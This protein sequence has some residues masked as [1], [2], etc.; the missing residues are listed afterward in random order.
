MPIDL[1]P[2]IDV[3]IAKFE[4]LPASGTKNSI[5]KRMLHYIPQVNEE[6]ADLNHLIE[7]Y[8]NCAPE[9]P[10]ALDTLY[11]IYNKQKAIV[12][13]YPEDCVNFCVNFYQV[14]HVDLF[15]QIKQNFERL[16]V[17]SISDSFLKNHLRKHSPSALYPLV[18][19]FANMEPAKINLIYKAL[20]ALKIDGAIPTSIIDEL[21]DFPW[22]EY[23]INF[24]GGNNSVNFLLQSIHGEQFVLSI[25]E[26]FNNTMQASLFLSEGNLDASLLEDGVL[27]GK[28]FKVYARR[29]ALLIGNAGEEFI[30]TLEIREYCSEG[31]LLSLKQRNLTNSVRLATAID[32]YKQM[33]LILNEIE[34]KGCAFPDMK[35]S[36][37]LMTRDSRLV[38]GDDKSLIFSNNGMISSDEI[39]S[40]IRTDYL[41]PPEVRNWRGGITFRDNPTNVEKLHAYQ[42]GKNLYQYLTGCENSYLRKHHIAEEFSFK[43]DIFVNPVGANLSGLIS[44]LTMLNHNRR[45]GVKEV[46]RRLQTFNCQLM[47]LELENFKFSTY[48]TVLNDFLANQ[49]MQVEAAFNDHRDALSSIETYLESLVSIFKNNTSLQLILNN[50]KQVRFGMF[51][52]TINIHLINELSDQFSQIPFEERL[53]IAQ[54]DFEGLSHETI[55]LLHRIENLSTASSAGST[56]EDVSEGDNKLSS[57][58]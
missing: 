1:L 46:Y 14:F 51:G 57:G 21:P 4:S 9:D 42:L 8:N 20:L 43:Y 45:P 2:L 12:S 52:T 41:C 22:N 53:K 18:E 16:G 7:R 35:N 36:N 34:L 40:V 56:Q 58:L 17:S 29:S 30:K 48:D 32:L 49:W 19:S 39:N 15:N 31:D 44:E 50:L 6:I 23:S 33:A 24:L 27:D 10:I 3:S 5:A 26:R 54:N 11:N 37:W 47:L 28:I 38:I 13:R 25:A 55:E